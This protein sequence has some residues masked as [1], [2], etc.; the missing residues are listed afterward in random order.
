[1]KQLMHCGTMQ[2]INKKEVILHEKAIA[3]LTVFALLFAF[4]ACG[5]TPTDTPKSNK[6]T[7]MTVPLIT[8][9]NARTTPSTL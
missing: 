9:A 2:K 7:L 8:S 4:S 3:L 1:M 6:K 5:K